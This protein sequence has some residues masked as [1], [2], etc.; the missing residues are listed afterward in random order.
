MTWKDAKFGM[1][2]SHGSASP[3]RLLLQP[4]SVVAAVREVSVDG[5]VPVRES[6]SG[7]TNRRIIAPTAGAYC[8]T[9][10]RYK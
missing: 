10:H 7:S 5:S 1:A 2:V 9:G 8:V 3:V 4:L 6:A